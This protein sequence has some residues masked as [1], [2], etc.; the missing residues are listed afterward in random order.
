MDTGWKTSI[1]PSAQCDLDELDDRVRSEAMAAILDL[2]EDPFPYG[3]IPLRGYVD[4]YRIRVYRDL[5][6]I[7]YRVSESGAEW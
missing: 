5:Y 6:R 1:L 3:F 4:I 2:A 7:V